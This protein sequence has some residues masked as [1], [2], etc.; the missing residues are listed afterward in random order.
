MPGQHTEHAFETVIEQHLLANGYASV[1]RDGF[2]RERAIFPDVALDFI[3]ETQPAEWAKLE[4]LHGAKTGEQVLADLCKWMD[5]NGSL[6]TLR[7]GFKCYGRMLCPRGCSMRWRRPR[8]GRACAPTS[9]ASA[10]RPP[11]PFPNHR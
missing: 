4:A 3:R 6:A 7:H 2:D 9:R 8:G 1:F 11:R 5:A 10:H